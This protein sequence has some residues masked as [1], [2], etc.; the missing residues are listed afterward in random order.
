LKRTASAETSLSSFHISGEEISA[1]NSRTESRD[2]MADIESLFEMRSHKAVSR[3]E[4]NDQLVK[5][6][7]SPFP[8]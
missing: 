7:D 6:M 4:S 2:T 1:S 3:M 8:R 5:S